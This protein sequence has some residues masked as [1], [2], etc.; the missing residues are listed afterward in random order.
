MAASPDEN[1]NGIPDECE[2]PGD[3]N[4]DGFVDLGDHSEFATC[5]TGPGVPLPPGCEA[6]DTN[7][8]G[9][10]DLSD[11]AGF[12]NGFSGPLSP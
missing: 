1:G 9:V 2:V 12:Q 4:G 3:F 7:G 10:A 6:A 8:D 5:L 11:F